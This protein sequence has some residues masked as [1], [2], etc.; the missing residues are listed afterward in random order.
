MDYENL[1]SRNRLIDGVELTCNDAYYYDATYEFR[2][3]KAKDVE[4]VELIDGLETFIRFSEDINASYPYYEIFEGVTGS[5]IDIGLVITSKEEAKAKAIKLAKD[6][7][8]RLDEQNL[9]VSTFK[10]LATS[11]YGISPRYKGFIEVNINRPK[12]LSEG[13]KVRITTGGDFLSVIEG[14]ITKVDDIERLNKNYKYYT[15]TYSNHC[16]HCFSLEKVDPSSINFSVIEL[17]T[18]EA[19]CRLNF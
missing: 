18:D 13:D 14:V 8:E 2:Q 17:L 1:I 4:V 15:L 16:T 5:V 12:S 10:K 19:G 6:K 9:L 3:V 7:V 11:I